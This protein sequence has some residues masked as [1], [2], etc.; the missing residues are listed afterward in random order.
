MLQYLS[1]IISPKKLL[2]K[3]ISLLSYWDR[4]STFT[5]Y[6]SLQRY[7]KLLNSHVGKYSRIC[8]NTHLLNTTVGNFSLI[9]RDTLVGLGA[10]P[11]NLLSPH[12]I[13][14]RKGRWKWHPEWSDGAIFQEEDYPITIGNGVWVARGCIIMDGV[15]IGDGAI[16]AAGAV[17]TKDVPPFAVVG[18]VPA[19]VL[20]YRFSEETINRL[21]K[22]QWWNLPDDEIT[23]VK[24]LFHIPNPT[25]EDIDTFFPGFE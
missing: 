22:I 4:R 10:H 21:L 20:K 6:T 11:T 16:I 5:P 17:V 2:Y 12:S 18:G 23:R 19:R 13:F 8:I 9:S 1:S 24:N 25:I 14:Y 3:D 7:S 15:T